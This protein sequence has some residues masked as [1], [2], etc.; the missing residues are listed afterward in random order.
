[1]EMTVKQYVE[2]SEDV[3][4]DIGVSEIY[5]NLSRYEKEELLELLLEDRTYNDSNYY[6]E[7]LML[8]KS[9]KDILNNKKIWDKII[10]LIKYEEQALKDYIIEELSYEPK[11]SKEN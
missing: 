4:I 6:I 7:G 5:E 8:G 9:D 1:M 2:I 10:R 11:L 3:E